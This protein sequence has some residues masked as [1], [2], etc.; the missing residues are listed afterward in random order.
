[1]IF[2]ADDVSKAMDKVFSNPGGGDDTPDGGKGKKGGKKMECIVGQSDSLFILGTSAKDIEKVLIRQTG[3][4]V[5]SLS[6]Q[7]VF[8]S[9][10]NSLFRD[11]MTYGWIH[12][13]PLVDVVTKKAAAEPA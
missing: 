7:S 12:L 3:G 2:S 13:K 9:T 4:A 8:Q 1:Y 11:S 10:Y 5:P 6:E